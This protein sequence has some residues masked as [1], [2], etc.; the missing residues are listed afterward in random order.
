MENAV[1][2]PRSV[3][4]VVSVVKLCA[5]EGVPIHFGEGMLK[6]ERVEDG[7]LVRTQ[8]QLFF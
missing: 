5:R 8:F 2:L 1:V 4:Q 7:F 3:E 6:I